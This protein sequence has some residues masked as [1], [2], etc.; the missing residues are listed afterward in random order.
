[1]HR[2]KQAHF[3]YRYERLNYAHAGHRTGNPEIVPTWTGGVTQRQTGESE[4]YGSRLRGQ[5]LSLPSTRFLGV[6]EFL[7]QAFP[8]APAK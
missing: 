7:Q 6:L 5:C 3:A 4:N 8:A 2:L 1:M